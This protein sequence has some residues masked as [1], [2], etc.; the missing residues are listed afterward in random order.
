MGNINQA[1]PNL[2]DLLQFAT[3]T[4]KQG[5]KQ[6]AQVLIQQVLEADK[7]NDRAW[8]LMAFTTDDPIDRRRCLKTALRLNPNNT[9]AKR[10]LDK[11]KK[12]RTRSDD[13]TM[14]YGTIGLIIILLA[15]VIACVAILVL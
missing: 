3:T 7:R 5:N 14:Y 11:M 9:S 13:K 8:V 1:A 15:A 4:L 10:A 12:V 2:E 6:G